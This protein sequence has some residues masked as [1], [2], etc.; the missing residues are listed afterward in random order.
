[1]IKVYKNKGYVIYQARDCYII[2]NERK[3][4]HAGHTHITNFDTAKY[5]VSLS[6]RK[7]IPHK[8]SCYL[9]ESLVRLTNDTRYKARL[10]K[11]INQQKGKK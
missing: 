3:P 6:L 8:M 5:L 1:M 11:A 9:L 7:S 2:H 4:F 10:E